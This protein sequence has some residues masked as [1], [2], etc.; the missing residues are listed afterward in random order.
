MVAGCGLCVCW[1]VLRVLTTVSLSRLNPLL[2]PPALVARRCC[3]LRLLSVWCLARPPVSPASCS[4]CLSCSHSSDDTDFG[5]SSFESALLHCISSRRMHPALFPSLI[6]SVH[7]SCHLM[8]GKC[9]PQP[10]L[11]PFFPGVKSIPSLGTLSFSHESDPFTLLQT[12]VFLS[13]FSL[14][15]IL[16]HQEN[17]ESVWREVRKEKGW[18]RQ[19][20][21]LLFDRQFDPALDT[22]TFAA[23][24]SMLQ[25][26]K[27]SE[28][29]VSFRPLWRIH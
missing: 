28:T 8:A 12:P 6:P 22:R 13:F 18:E 9:V 4:C 26:F 20:A 16:L 10:Q 21:A 3:W 2:V 5:P 19:K 7:L 1:L 11:P 17:G 14:V 24:S 25:H 23:N 15:S 29:H 27:P